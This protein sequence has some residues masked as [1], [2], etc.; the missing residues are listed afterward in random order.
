MLSPVPARQLRLAFLMHSWKDTL[1]YSSNTMESALQYEKFLNVSPLLSARPG[2]VLPAPAPTDG[3]RGRAGRG[4]RRATG[5][6]PQSQSLADLLESD[7]HI[8]LCPWGAFPAHLQAELLSQAEP[9]SQEEPL[10]QAE[11]ATGAVSA[12]WFLW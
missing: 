12:L 9:L 5:L 2:G 6:A 11:P 3:A 1:D 8:F 10:S 4:P 7:A